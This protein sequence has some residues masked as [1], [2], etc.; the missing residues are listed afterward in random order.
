M[1][2]R[3]LSSVLG[4]FASAHGC[5]V[6]VSSPPKVKGKFKNVLLV[7]VLVTCRSMVCAEPLN[8]TRLSSPALQRSL[9]VF[10]EIT[11]QKLHLILQF[12][13]I[14]NTL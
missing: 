12:F 1:V 8:Q 2:A 14:A 11:G 9:S 4:K 10:D 6:S 3:E 13:S 5:K 7:E